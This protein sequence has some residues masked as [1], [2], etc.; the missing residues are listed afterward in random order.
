[1]TLKRVISR[2]Y[3]ET[4]DL[5]EKTEFD[6]LSDSWCSPFPPKSLGKVDNR[7]GDYDSTYHRYPVAV[8]GHLLLLN[9]KLYEFLD[10]FQL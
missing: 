5:R 1:M 7:Y 10:N 3:F 2:D 8:N 4:A 9:R 6:A